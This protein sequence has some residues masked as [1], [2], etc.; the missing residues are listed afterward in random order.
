MT[1][2]FLVFC[3]KTD[4]AKRTDVA[5]ES[6][7]RL[8]DYFIWREVEKTDVACAPTSVFFDVRL[9]YYFLTPGGVGW[10]APLVTSVFL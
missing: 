2:V 8:F 1:S 6:D 5:P 7:V 3:K 9:F 4:V 10:G